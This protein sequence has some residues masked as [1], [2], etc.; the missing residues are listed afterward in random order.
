MTTHKPFFAVE[1]SPIK[2]TTN[3]LRAQVAAEKEADKRQSP[4]RIYEDGSMHMMVYPAAR[5]ARSAENVAKF[6]NSF[7]A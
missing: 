7:G 4:V 6:V 2:P 3:Y 1:F 5:L